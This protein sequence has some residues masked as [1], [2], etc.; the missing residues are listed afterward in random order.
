L[1]LLESGKAEARGVL[2]GKLFEY[3]V[4]GTPILAVGID[5]QNAA[6]ELLESTGTGCCSTN[7]DE[8]KQLFLAATKSGKFDFFNPRIELITQYSRDKQAQLIIDRL[9]LL[10]GAA[11]C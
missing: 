2:T 6:G 7:A 1:L 10:Q 3:L 4:S 8:L 5:R 11:P 9:S